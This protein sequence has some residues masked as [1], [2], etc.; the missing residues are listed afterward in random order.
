ML[1][2]NIS[3]TFPSLHTVHIDQNAVPQ[4]MDAVAF[5]PCW[6][7]NRI[8]KLLQNPYFSF[9]YLVWGRWIF[10]GEQRRFHGAENLDFVA[11][12][13][14]FVFPSVV[15]MSCRCGHCGQE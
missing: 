12:Y 5:T 7:F 4:M 8:F 1:L 13:I 9:G 2:E 11:H 14:D 6:W 15:H 3:S 10:D